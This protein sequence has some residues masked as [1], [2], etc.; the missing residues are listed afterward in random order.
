[1]CLFCVSILTVESTRFSVF[2]LLKSSN[3]SYAILRI[4]RN[5]DILGLPLD[6]RLPTGA[7][8]LPVVYLPGTVGETN[9]R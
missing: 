4:F 8:I 7:I 6:Q 2:V 1:M 3:G 5:D 9:K